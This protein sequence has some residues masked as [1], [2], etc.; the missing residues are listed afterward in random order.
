M[1]A[2]VDEISVCDAAI[3]LDRHRVTVWDWCR[4]GRLKARRRGR[5]YFP[6]L[7]AVAA[8]AARDRRVAKLKALK[9]RVA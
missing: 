2:R 5:N 3:V 8:L 9:A 1:L 6:L 4:T 7:A